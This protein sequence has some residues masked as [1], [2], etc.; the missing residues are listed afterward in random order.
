[1]NE[2]PPSTGGD[3]EVLAELSQKIV[4]LTKVIAFL[5]T[6]SDTYESRCQTLRTFYEGEVQ[7][8]AG[9]AAAHIQTQTRHTECATKW[10]QEQLESLERQ[11]KRQQE[12]S[13]VAISDLRAVAK[14]KEA[15][16][17]RTLLAA[18]AARNS[19]LVDLRAEA[20]RV[21]RTLSAAKSQVRNNAMWFSRE[22]PRGFE[23]KTRHG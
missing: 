2:E 13:G 17:R 15:E 12:E 4:Q 8:V 20:E 6:R 10:F 22:C 23:N 5:H 18:E 14:T 7:Q 3:A 1:M 16:L 21:T 19:V 11:Q 9:A